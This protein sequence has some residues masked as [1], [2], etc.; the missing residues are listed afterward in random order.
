MSSTYIVLD[1]VDEGQSIHCLL[2]GTTSHN[3]NDV[4]ERYCGFCHRFHDD[5]TIEGLPHEERKQFPLTER[6]P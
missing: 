5:A 1:L 4:R 6:F 2:C 3:P